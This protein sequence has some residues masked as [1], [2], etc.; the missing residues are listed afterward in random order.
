MDRKVI[1]VVVEF[2]RDAVTSPT[3]RNNP[4]MLELK[5]LAT[6]RHL[7]TGKMHLF[8]Q[9][10]YYLGTSSDLEIIPPRLYFVWCIRTG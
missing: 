8:A 10:Y 3:N 1:E 9:D 5:Y 4:I 6:A 2:V 7:A